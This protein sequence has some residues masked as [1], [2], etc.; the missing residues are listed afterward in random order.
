MDTQRRVEDILRAYQPPLSNQD[1]E[2]ITAKIL[3]V[4]NPTEKEAVKEATTEP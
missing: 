2:T 4:T 3:A 1:I